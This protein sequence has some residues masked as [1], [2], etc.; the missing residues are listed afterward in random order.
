MDRKVVLITGATDGIG[1]AA[2][3]ELARRGMRV[4]VHGRNP[5]RVDRVVRAIR[6]TGGQ[7]DGCLADLESFR[8]VRRLGEELLERAEKLDVLINNA[9]V[10][11]PFRR[12][13]ADGHE[14]TFQVNY[15]SHFL[16]TAF[17]RPLVERSAPSRILSTSSVAHQRGEIDF[18]DLELERGY[19]GYSAY[20]ATKL[21]QIAFT[22]SLAERL[23]GTGVTAN[24]F[25]PGVIDTKLLRAGFGRTSADSPEAGARTPVLLATAPELD[26]VTGRYFDRGRETKPS[27][28]ARD[29]LVRERLWRVSEQLTGVEWERPA[30]LPR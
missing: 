6:R 8:Q 2:A 9:G 25:H 19:H 11:E 27:R 13:T 30:E 24:C 21:M 28:R 20:A 15:L 16:L 23:G 18:D 5:D 26:H 10:Y 12:V 17:L 14:V 22:L 4:L 29:P 1:R 3:L 7:A